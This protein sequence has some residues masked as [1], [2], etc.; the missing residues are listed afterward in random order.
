MRP[1][2]DDRIK[3][4]FRHER[5]RAAKSE[6][7]L[8]R[9]SRA[10][11]GRRSEQDQK[12]RA[13]VEDEA[14]SAEQYRRKKALS[15]AKAR[16]PALQA[17]S[18][19]DQ[20]R[21]RRVMWHVFGR[22]GKRR[23]ELMVPFVAKDPEP[24]LDAREH[25]E[26]TKLLQREKQKKEKL[27]RIHPWRRFYDRQD[28]TPWL[29]Q[30]LSPIEKNWDLAMLHNYIKDQ[31]THQQSTPGVSFPRNIIRDVNPLSKIP[32]EDIYGRP[33]AK[34]RVTKL[35]R[36][37]WKRVAEKIL[38]PVDKGE[39]DLLQALAS[40]DASAEMYTMP[41]RR[42]IAS[43]INTD[44]NGQDRWDWT[45]YATLPARV[46]ERPRTRALTLLTGQSDP[47]PHSRNPKVRESP[48]QYSRREVRR[49]YAKIWEAT[50]YME[51][52]GNRKDKQAQRP[53]SPVWGKV[54]LIPPPPSFVQRQVYE[55]VD[56]QGR[57]IG[58]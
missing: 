8:A 5:E 10:S 30:H 26:R 17:A 24:P 54:G 21:L 41:R 27:A 6:R 3:E 55:G 53:Q 18:S 45:S 58:G 23:R 33:L 1:Y 7:E 32:K 20:R 52:R 51:P 11:G 29:R 34:R 57:K 2:L 43:P 49:E 14:R 39:W 47:N 4:D 50:S 48:R 16:L 13:L 38:P 35:S 36:K 28:P 19:G 44:S 31:K 37:W 15:D 46:A 25:E 56:S 40:G 42:P 9:T 22:L 12:Q